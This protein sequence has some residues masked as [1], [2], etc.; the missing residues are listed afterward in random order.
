WTDPSVDS[1]PRDETDKPSEELGSKESAPLDYEK[2]IE[3]FEG[4]ESFLT[5]VLE[6]FLNNV[7]DQIKTIEQAMS[8]GDFELI[9][10][11]A[12]SIKGG[13]ANLTALDLAKSALEIENIGASG[14][15]DAGFD[16]I[17]TLKKEFFRLE[18]Y[19][20]QLDHST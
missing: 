4:D 16:V 13:A 2:A 19:F 18:S 6:G 3:E 12:H 9:R 15:I 5:E 7:K 14:T 10:K 17:E 1:T 20:S 11:E 8:D